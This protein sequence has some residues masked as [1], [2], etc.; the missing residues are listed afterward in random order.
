MQVRFGPFVLDAE[1]R[2]LLRDSRPVSLS[3]RAVEL[4]SAGIL[5]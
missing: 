1:S 2:E 4:S 3:P 5:L